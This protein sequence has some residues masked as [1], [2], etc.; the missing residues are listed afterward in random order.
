[1][2]ITIIEDDKI[3]ANNIAKKLMKNWY[4]VDVYFDI[5]EFK[6]NYN[7]DTDLYI[8]DIS[9]WNET[10]AWFTIIK[11]LRNYKTLSTPILITSW[12][13]DI[14][15]KVY[16][17]DIWADDYLPKPFA[18]NELIARIRVLLR[19]NT[20][21]NQSSI[22]KHW[23][24]EFDLKTKEVKNEWEI[25][26]FAKKELLIIELFLLNKWELISKT[27]LINSIWWTYDSLDISDNTINVTLSRVRKKL[28][29]KFN[30]KTIVN[31]WYI[32]S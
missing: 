6:L 32:L 24:I 22:I 15:K 31:G 7:D 19:R 5:N 3:M 10:W 21:D 27:K 28:W 25:V 4:E 1:M 26:F 14:E 23:N 30:L 18:P 9:L 2:N 16:W 13:N 29:D 20:K 11:W 8:I 17:L 12:Y